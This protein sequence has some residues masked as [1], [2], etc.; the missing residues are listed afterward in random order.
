M[1]LIGES[2]CV[3]DFGKVHSGLNDFVAGLLNFEVTHVLFR[4]H[5]ET[6]FEFPL[7]GA[8]REVGGGG[9][10]GDGDV[11]AERLVHELQRGP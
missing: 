10:F 9:E 11:V 7:E 6:G 4:G 5:V 3:A 1:A 8:E 2:A